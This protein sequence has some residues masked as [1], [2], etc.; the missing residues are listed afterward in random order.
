MTNTGRP[1]TAKSELKF[2][3]FVGL[4]WSI[5]NK[6]RISNMI[7]DEDLFQELSLVWLNCKKMYNPSKGI[8]FV[9][10][11]YTSAINFIMRVKERNNRDIYLWSLD[12][13]ISLSPKHNI[14]ISDLYVDEEQ[15]IEQ[16]YINEDIIY[17]FLTHP[18]GAIAK[19]LLQGKTISY[20]ADKL[21]VDQ[22]T[23]TRWMQKMID[24]VRRSQFEKDIL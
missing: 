8:D 14:P 10:Y 24:D 11:Y 3:D 22:S 9:S 1:M 15:S 7:E 5:V 19:Y 4:T 20:A 16:A 12:Y 18:Y 6:Q 21:E 13:N 23:A 17:K 2:D